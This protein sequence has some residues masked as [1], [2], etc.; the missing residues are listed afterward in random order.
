MAAKNFLLM[1]EEVFYLKKKLITK[2]PVESKKFRTALIRVKNLKP[3][4]FDA[5][6]D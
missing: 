1:R 3:T 5:A 6:K 4:K 2:I